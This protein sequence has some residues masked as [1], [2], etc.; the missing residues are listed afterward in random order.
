MNQQPPSRPDEGRHGEERGRTGEQMGGQY[1]G[2]GRQGQQPYGGQQAGAPS[3]GQTGQRG[4][5]GQ[6]TAQSQQPATGGEQGSMGRQPY[7]GQQGSMGQQG[8]MG[9]Q[10]YGGQQGSMGRQESMGRHRGATQQGMLDQREVATAV[11]RAIEVCAYCADQC[12]RDADPGMVECIRMCEDVTELGEA[13]L[14]LVP[15][16]SRYGQQ[17][18]GMFQEAA[19]D[20]AMECSRH[21]AGHCQECATVLEQSVNAI[22]QAGGATRQS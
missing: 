3:A 1:G 19:T 4:S 11:A 21:P 2:A 8:T 15:R 7:G 16:D 13:A 9:Q 5:M 12:I 22:Q 18:L 10:P 20:C 17:V 6:P 14:S